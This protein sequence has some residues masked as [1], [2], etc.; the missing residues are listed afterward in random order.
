ME[1]VSSLDWENIWDELIKKFSETTVEVG[2]LQL[3][4]LSGNGHIVSCCISYGKEKVLFKNA[5]AVK[6]CTGPFLENGDSGSLVFI[7][8][9]NKKPFAYG[10]CEVDELHLPQHQTGSIDDGSDTSSIWSEDEYCIESTSESEDKV[11]AVEGT[12]KSE[13]NDIRT[14]GVK[15]LIKC[16]KAN[17]CHNYAKCYDEDSDDPEDSE[18]MFQKDTGPYFICLR[19]DT[20][21]E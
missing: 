6:G 2:K 3:S 17:E 12:E 1:D 8:D 19:L 11:E 18:I 9:D 16:Q 20:A 7:N 21:L 13:Y 14:A 10:V 4:P 5:I 15:D